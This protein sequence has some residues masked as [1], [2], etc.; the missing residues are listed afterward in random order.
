MQFEWDDEKDAANRR[1]HG[2]GFARACRIF[3]GFVLSRLDE[4]FAYGEERFITIGQIVEEDPV[5]LV[6]VNTY[7]GGTTRIISARRASRAERRSYEAAVQE[8]ADR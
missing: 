1:K 5:V 3:E 2:V 8:R 4:R 7:R 6:L